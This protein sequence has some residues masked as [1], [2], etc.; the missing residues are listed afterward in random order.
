[1]YIHSLPIRHNTKET[2]T[3]RDSGHTASQMKT[4]KSSVFF[5]LGLFALRKGVSAAPVGFELRPSPSSV[6][7]ES[8]INFPNARSTHISLLSLASSLLWG[9]GVLISHPQL[10]TDGKEFYWT[11][12]EH[13]R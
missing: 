4:C 11:E 9:S 12:Q 2:I 13:R 3:E 10:V 7:L 6:N 1:M 8:A 5:G